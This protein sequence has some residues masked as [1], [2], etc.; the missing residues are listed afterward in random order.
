MP[1]FLDG[2][3][4]RHNAFI[5]DVD[6]QLHL[7]MRHDLNRHKIPH[8]LRFS[9]RSL[10]EASHHILVGGLDGPKLDFQIV[11]ECLYRFQRKR[12]IGGI[13]GII[14]LVP[15]KYNRPPWPEQ[16]E[17][18]GDSDELYQWIAIVS[19]PEDLP[20]TLA[21]SVLGYHNSESS[22]R[23]WSKHAGEDYG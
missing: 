2:S 17:N 14:N 5:I 9:G 3:D 7:D 18:P 19:L 8:K 1:S 22:C 20:A 13:P 21:T 15:I 16:S 12:V 10:K 23:E 6:V 4:D 11:S